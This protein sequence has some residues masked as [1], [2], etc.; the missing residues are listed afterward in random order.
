MRESVFAVLG[1]LGGKSFLDLFSGSG[2]VALEAASR[3]ASKIE[4][5]EKDPL[6]RRTLLLNVAIAM[7]SLGIRIECRFVSAELFLRR[8]GSAF[9]VIF[10]DPPFSY[11]F[12]R[13][14]L[15]TVAAREL[16]SPGGVFIVHRPRED[17]L[18]DDAPPLVKTDSRTYGRSI[19]DF[20]SRRET[21]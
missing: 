5:V 3:G 19:V 2:I 6:K 9:D 12:R 11:R 1:D 7:E 20:F 18:P 13:D 4:L 10:C 15:Q 14:I 8:A 17:A 21:S 16:L